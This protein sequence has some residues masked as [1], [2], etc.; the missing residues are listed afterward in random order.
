[1]RGRER[2]ALH[3]NAFRDRCVACGAVQP[4]SGIRRYGALADDEG[5]DPTLDAA[6]TDGSEAG[7]DAGETAAG[8]DEMV[9][10]GA[11]GPASLGVVL[12]QPASAIRTTGRKIFMAVG[13]DRPH[14]SGVGKAFAIV[15]PF[16]RSPRAP[17]RSRY[18]MP[19]VDMVPP[20]V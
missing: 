4:R 16:L 19:R 8:D 15:L 5:D 7:D 6:G 18:Q 13:I 10:L 3:G 9:A 20:S 17:I 14:V 11:V 1:M 12:L 2:V